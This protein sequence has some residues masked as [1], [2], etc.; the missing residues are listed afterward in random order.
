MPLFPALPPSQAKQL[1][2]RRIQFFASSFMI[3]CDLCSWYG[4]GFLKSSF[5]VWPLLAPCEQKKP[6]H[7]G[8][9]H[10]LPSSQLWDFIRRGLGKEAPSWAPIFF[11]F[12]YN[13]FYFLLYKY[14]PRLHQELPL[15]RILQTLDCCL[16][17]LFYSYT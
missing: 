10:L 11:F 4:T 1:L 14:L 2:Q 7:K 5:S 9:S 17:R 16:R 8:P 13:A 3:L 6:M 15:L 12:F